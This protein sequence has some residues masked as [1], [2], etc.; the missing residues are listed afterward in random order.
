MAS[1]NFQFVF[2]IKENLQGRILRFQTE[3][4]TVP[5]TGQTIAQVSSSIHLL[6]FPPLAVALML[7]GSFLFSMIE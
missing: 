4:W 2:Q 3:R 5:W 6:R 1:A 7:I